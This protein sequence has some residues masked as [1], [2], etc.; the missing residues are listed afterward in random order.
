MD[1]N[2]LNRSLLLAAQNDDWP[3]AKQLI[4]QGADILFQDPKGN[5]AVMLFV[6]NNNDHAVEQLTA[7][8]P[9]VLYQHD[10]K[11]RWTAPLLLA[12]KNHP[13]YILFAKSHPDIIHQKGYGGTAAHMFARHGNVDMLV[14]IAAIDESV[15]DQPDNIGQMPSHILA[16]DQRGLELLHLAQHYPQ[17]LKQQND[18]GHYPIHLLMPEISDCSKLATAFPFVLTQEDRYGKT[19]LMLLTYYSFRGA[20]EVLRE[21]LQRK[22]E[23]ATHRNSRGDTLL[24]F[25]KRE[26][27]F[28][29]ALGIARQLRP[30]MSWKQL[31]RLSQQTPPTS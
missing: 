4:E 17:V 23:Y 29:R 5:T 7:I 26:V 10:S 6:M 30:R 25:A 1:Q 9:D 2:T 18:R 14:A 20:K 3:L 22:P 15:L 31:Y 27:G 21:N 28:F 13:R 12:L 8:N 19:L 11:Y 24:S 16:I